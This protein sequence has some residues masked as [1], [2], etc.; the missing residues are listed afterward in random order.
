MCFGLKD[1]DLN[2]GASRLVNSEHTA[3][4]GGAENWE[5]VWG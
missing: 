4:M 3:Q 5:G 1:T 2:F